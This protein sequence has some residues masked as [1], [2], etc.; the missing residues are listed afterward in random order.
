[1]RRSLVIFLVI[2]AGILIFLLHSVST[3]LS[4]LIEDASGD[5]IPGQ[6]F[7]LQTPHSSKPGRP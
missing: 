2:A 3:L 7:L 4:L 6:K 5:A 1:M